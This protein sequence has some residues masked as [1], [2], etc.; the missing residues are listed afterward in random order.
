MFLPPTKKEEIDYRGEKFYTSDELKDKFISMIVNHKHIKPVSK[1]FENLVKN[2]DI[3]PC[4]VTSG[5]L[6][7]LKFKLFTPGKYKKLAG[8]YDYDIG[9][10]FVLMNYNVNFLSIVKDINIMGEIALHELMHMVADR[11]PKSFIRIFKNDLE[12]YYTNLLKDIFKVEGEIKDIDKLVLF[13]FSEFERKG[14]I[15]MSHLRKYSDILTKTFK[16]KSTMDDNTFEETLKN[17]IVLIKL[18]LV[19]NTGSFYRIFRSGKFEHIIKPMYVSYYKTFK[20][21]TLTTI[22]IQ[23]LVFPSEVICIMS[24]KPNRNIYKAIKEI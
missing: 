15:T 12:N 5:F 19:N 11:K 2:G 10:I 3:I 14:N 21:E 6:G 22:C 1:E 20:M 18:F 13:L 4:W 8:F 17:Y 9:K 7:N 23:E 16:D 24:E